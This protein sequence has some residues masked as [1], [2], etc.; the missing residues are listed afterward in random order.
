MMTG[1]RC[2]EDDDVIDM[3]ACKVHPVTCEAIYP[4]TGRGCHHAPGHAGHHAYIEH[5][6]WEQPCRKQ[7]Q[8]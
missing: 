3:T 4:S 1:C 5:V 2:T 8:R 7:A 6:V